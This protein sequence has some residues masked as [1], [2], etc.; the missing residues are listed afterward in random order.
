MSQLEPE[1]DPFLKRAIYD[2]IGVDPYANTE[3]V[4]ERLQVMAA[5]LEEMSD[6]EKAQRIGIFQEA[7]KI[8]KSP[9]NRVLINTLILDPIHTERVVEQLSKLPQNLNVDGLKMPPLDVS[10]IFV[11]GESTEIA[12]VD[13]SDVEE[14]TSLELDLGE[15]KEML[16]Q[17]PEPRHVSFDS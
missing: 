6:A 17:Q 16:N 13:F 7:M 11:E 10:S 12:K 4:N 1:C 3:K 14:D 9:R 5:E 8:L 2:E 15:I